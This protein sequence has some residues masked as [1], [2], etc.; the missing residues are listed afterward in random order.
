MVDV[1]TFLL[2]LLYILGSILLVALIV[3]VVKLV[4]TVNRVNGILDE[5]D[6]KIEKIDKALRIVDVITDNMAMLSD[7]LAEGLSNTIR[8]IFGRR[9]IGKGDGNN[10]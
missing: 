6:K 8:K 3:L 9:K 5:V 10:E 7:K 2:M 1:N 4:N